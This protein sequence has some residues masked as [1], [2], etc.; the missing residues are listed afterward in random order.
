[1]PHRTHRRG[2]AVTPATAL[3]GIIVLGFV[4]ALMA[5]RWGLDLYGPWLYQ[6]L[7]WMK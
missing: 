1:M 4:V 6:H 5:T 2:R 7:E 3:M